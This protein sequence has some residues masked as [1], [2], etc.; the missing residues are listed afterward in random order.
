MVSFIPIFVFS[1]LLLSKLIGEMNTVRFGLLMATCVTA[2][3]AVSA[4]FWLVP[5]ERLP[6]LA[7]RSC[8]IKVVM[9]LAKI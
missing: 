4:E 3:Q 2:S 9:C 6:Q 7:P 8:A 5:D 1:E